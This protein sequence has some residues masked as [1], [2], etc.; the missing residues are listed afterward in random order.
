MSNAVVFFVSRSSG[1]SPFSI[2]IMRFIHIYSVR[3][4]FFA[5]AAVN[6][7]F[8]YS[9]HILANVEASR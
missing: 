2:F 8:T 1:I 6:V 7:V 5:A 9:S 3:C 4:F